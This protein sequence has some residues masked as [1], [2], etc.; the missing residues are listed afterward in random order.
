MFK[1]WLGLG[2]KIT[3]LGLGKDHGVGSDHY[4]IMVKELHRHGDKVME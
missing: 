1:V 2:T 3:W 4:C